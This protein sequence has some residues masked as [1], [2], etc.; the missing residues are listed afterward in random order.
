MTGVSMREDKSSALQESP[1]NRL[2]AILIDMRISKVLLEQLKTHGSKPR[3]IIMSSVSVREDSPTVKEAAKLLSVLEKETNATVTVWYSIPQFTTMDLKNLLQTL[4]WISL[5]LFNTVSDKKTQEITKLTVITIDL[6][7]LLQAEPSNA[8]VKPQLQESHSHAVKR[9]KCVDA[10]EEVK[11]STELPPLLP[12]Q[13][14]PS[15]S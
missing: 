5:K 3:S 12:T 13:K 8:S 9:V 11:C 2:S 7:I 15:R 10:Q 4:K 1:I 14:P 6:E